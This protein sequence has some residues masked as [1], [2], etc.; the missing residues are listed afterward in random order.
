[1][2]TKTFNITKKIAKHGS[3]SIIV[4]PRILEQHLKPGMI[5]ELNINIIEN[6]I[7]LEGGK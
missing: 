4:V 3:Q 1:M 6:K 7:I 5:V 2:E